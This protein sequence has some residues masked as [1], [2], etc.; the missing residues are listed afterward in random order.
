MSY[1]SREILVLL[2]EGQKR[3]LGG[4]VNERCPPVPSA[5]RFMLETLKPAL[6]LSNYFTVI[7]VCPLAIHVSGTCR[8]K[9]KM[10][11]L[12]L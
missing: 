4:A 6:K 9:E 1:S 10:S 5:P 7:N 3:A 12:E 11:H 8:G 2:S